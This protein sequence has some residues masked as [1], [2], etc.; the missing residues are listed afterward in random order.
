MALSSICRQL[1]AILLGEKK[2]PTSG[3]LVEGARYGGATNRGPCQSDRG[4]TLVAIITNH[5]LFH[6]DDPLG[7]L[8]HLSKDG[9]HPICDR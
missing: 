4:A 8:S 9:R 3:R 6:D 1:R 5:S 2:G 7:T